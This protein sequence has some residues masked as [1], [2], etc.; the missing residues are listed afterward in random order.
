MMKI[1]LPAWRY[2]AERPDG[3]YKKEVRNKSQAFSDSGN[4][5]FTTEDTKGTKVFMRK[6]N[7]ESRMDACLVMSMLLFDCLSPLSQAMLLPG[8]PIIHPDREDTS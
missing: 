4:G 8:Y 3:R 5:F 1:S 2:K 6:D 7:D